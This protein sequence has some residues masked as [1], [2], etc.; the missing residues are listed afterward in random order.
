MARARLLSLLFTWLND[1]GR[2]LL[3]TSLPCTTGRA[4]ADLAPILA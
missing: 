2:T 3:F 1:V 4:P